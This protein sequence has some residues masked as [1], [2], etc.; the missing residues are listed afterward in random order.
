MEI[1]PHHDPGGAI[2]ADEDIV[3]ELR[4]CQGGEGFVKGEDD[5]C[6]DAEPC[7]IAVF[8]G[9]G[10][11]RATGRSG[12]KNTRGCGSKVSMAVGRCSLRASD[13]VAA[14]TA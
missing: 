1:V 9:G 14:I 7:A 8:S 12:V 10:V 5:G 2:A 11:M 13:R 6:I 4:G 3:H